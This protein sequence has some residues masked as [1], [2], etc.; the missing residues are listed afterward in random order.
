MGFLSLLF[1][2][3]KQSPPDPKPTQSDK[4]K[5]GQV[6]QYRTRKGEEGSRLI[7]GKVEQMGSIGIVIHI[8][9]IGLRI[10]NPHAP[11]GV[12]NTI[13][14]APVAEANLSESVTTLVSEGG[15]LDGFHE[16]YDT[17][18]K[19]GKPGVLTIPVSEIVD[20]VERAFAQ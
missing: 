5:P 9:L 14:H 17:F 4:F 7:I 19:A 8:K 13:A 1:G 11:G 3:G 12:S 6:W 2:C 18:K 20:S 16:G 10:M 15:N